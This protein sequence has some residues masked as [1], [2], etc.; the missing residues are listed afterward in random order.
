MNVGEFYKKNIEDV[1]K[2]CD[3]IDVKVYFNENTNEVVELEVKYML[4]TSGEDTDKSLNI[5]SFINDNKDNT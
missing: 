5:P 4:P 2:E 3:I 1:I